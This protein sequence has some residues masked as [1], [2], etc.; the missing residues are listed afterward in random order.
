MSASIQKLM[1]GRIYCLL[2][3]LMKSKEQE[4]VT[5]PSVPASC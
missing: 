4:K 1:A 3:I 5:N 2:I